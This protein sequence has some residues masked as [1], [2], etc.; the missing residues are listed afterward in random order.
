MS[1]DPFFPP[2]SHLL[3][4]SQ[5]ARILQVNPEFVRKLLRTGRLKGKLLGNRWRVEAIVLRTYIDTLPEDA[6]R[7][8][9]PSTETRRESSVHPLPQAVNR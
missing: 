3:E 2:A 1:I 4:V 7:M 5:V 6:K 9:R 8:A